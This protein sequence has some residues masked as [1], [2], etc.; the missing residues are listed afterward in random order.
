MTSLNNLIV[1]HQRFLEYKPSNNP[2]FSDR[3][4]INESNE[5]AEMELDL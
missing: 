4:F 2:L 1:H 5:N 3:D